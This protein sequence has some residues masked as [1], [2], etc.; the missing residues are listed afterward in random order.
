MTAF[1]ALLACL[2]TPTLT[3]SHALVLAE[4]I[5]RLH[6]QAL[7]Q[8]AAMDAEDADMNLR[9]AMEASATQEDYGMTGRMGG[10]A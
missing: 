9:E 1:L 3:R 5:D 6:E 10:G 7:A 2:N 4:V 8:D